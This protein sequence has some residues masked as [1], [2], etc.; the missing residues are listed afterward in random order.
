MALLVLLNNFLHDFSAAGWIFSTI[1][2]WSILRKKNR[3][4]KEPR[5]VTD[6]LKMIMFLMRLSLAGI[7]IFGLLRALAYREFEWNAEAGNSQIVLLIV[8]HVILAGVLIF[9]FVYYN[10]AKKARKKGLLNE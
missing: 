9:G 2:L 6:I 7:I 1:I 8:K 5:V 10:R 4:D 3:L